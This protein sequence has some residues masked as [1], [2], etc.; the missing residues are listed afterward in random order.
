MLEIAKEIAKTEYK[1][2]DYALLQEKQKQACTSLV[3]YQSGT[4]AV[5]DEFDASGRI[6]DV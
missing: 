1:G 6:N 2:S 4:I 3:T 5:F